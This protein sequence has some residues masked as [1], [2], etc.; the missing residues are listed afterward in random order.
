MDFKQIEAFVYV[1]RHKSFSKAADAIYLTQPTVSAHINSLENEI[2]TKLIDRSAKEV[3]P[4]EAGK[5]FF[6]YALNLMNTRDAA[7]FSLNGFTKGS[8]GK[9]EIAASTVPGQYIIPELILGFQKKYKNIVFNLIQLDTKQVIEELLDNSFEIGV[10]GSIINNEKLKYEKL[11]EDKMVIITP[12]NKRIAEID[13]NKIS[14]ED[15]KNENFIFRETGSGTRKEF[16]KKLI[17][18]DIDPKSINVVAQMNSTEAIK[19]AVSLGLGVSIVS[20]IS[21]EDYVKFGLINAYELKEFSLNREFYMVYHKSRP[22]SP[23][24]DMF[25]EYAI[26]YYENH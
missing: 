11:L 25:K 16:E 6:E 24:T 22:M 15:L 18:A 21:A 13:G 2:G 17:K 4:T 3:L 19:Q 20:S 5:I 23:I 26:S 9:L 12:K 10:V 14:M 8:S 7:V 1:V